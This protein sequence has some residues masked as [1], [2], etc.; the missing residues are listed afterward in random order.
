MTSET[1]PF[2]MTESDLEQTALTWL[3]SLGYQIRTGLD[4]GPGEPGA[5]RSDYKQTVL[6]G[7]LRRAI[8]S[9]NPQLPPGAVDDTVRKITR[10]FSPNLIEN[11]RTFHRMLTDGVA[12]SYMKE[13][14]EFHD[15]VWLIDLDDIENNDWLAINQFS[16]TANRCTRRPDILV[17]VNGLPLAVMELKNAAEEKATIRHAF[18]QL[19]A[20]KSDIPSLFVYNE[21]MIV[22]DGIQARTGSLTAG[23]DRFMP[24]RTVDGSELAPKTS[25]E[26]EILIKGIFHKHRFLDLILNFIAFDDDGSII[27]K[28]IASYHQFHAVNKAVECTFSA[29]GY[30]YDPTR[31]NGR[32]PPRPHY[33]L[34]PNTSHYRSPC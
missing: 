2:K 31:L 16:I 27:T 4:T 28:K 22:S 33:G 13:G 6:E 1:S 14:R 26:L 10:P 34:G 30:P 15:L 24:W 23:W 12:V 21:L 5:E 9:I 19:Q 7:R 18:N 25:V 3:D 17:F 32:F 20:Y 29:Y 8:E 11:N